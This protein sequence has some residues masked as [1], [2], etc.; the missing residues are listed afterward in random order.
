[1]RT[2]TPEPSSTNTCPRGWTKRVRGDGA[3]SRVSG[4]TPAAFVTNS[5]SLTTRSTGMVARTSASAAAARAAAVPTTTTPGAAC[6]MYRACSYCSR[7]ATYKATAEHPATTA[8]TAATAGAVR[9]RCRAASRRASRDA[10]GSRGATF[11]A[12]TTSVPDSATSPN[13]PRAS[14]TE[15]RNGECWAAASSAR[16]GGRRRRRGA[17]GAGD[18]RRRGRPRDLTFA[19]CRPVPR[20]P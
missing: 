17:R 14:P 4:D 18:A 6:G 11:A 16:R 3:T 5:L 7:E 2:A 15:T 13:S 12:S 20:F 10:S 9:P 19:R 8:S 1:M